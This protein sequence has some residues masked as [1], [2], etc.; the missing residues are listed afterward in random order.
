MFISNTLQEFVTTTDV[1]TPISTGHS[2]ILFSLSR[3]KGCLENFP[4]INSR[5]EEIFQNFKLKVMNILYPRIL[6]LVH[7]KQVSPRLNNF[8]YHLAQIF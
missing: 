2:P 4:N 3:E 5:V 8:S 6:Q 7:P 1:L